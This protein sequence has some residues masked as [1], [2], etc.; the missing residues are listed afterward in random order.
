MIPQESLERVN[1]ALEFCN[2]VSVVEIGSNEQYANATKLYR[3]LNGYIKA[4]EE[5]RKRVKEPYFK[6]G[7][8]IDAWFNAPAADLLN[9]KSK[10]DPA[11]RAYDRKIEEARLEEQRR[12]NAIAEA[13]RKKKEQAAALERQKAE[14]KRR[15]AEEIAQKDAARAAELRRQAEAADVRAQEKENRAAMVTAPIAQ[16]ATPKAEG[17]S[18][19]QNWKMQI[20]NPFEFVKWCVENNFTMLLMPNPAACKAQAGIIR[21]ETV[22][23]WGKI[24]NDESLTGRSL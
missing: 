13:E 8:E 22:Y 1:K 6:K 7:K 2:S 17:I 20:D 23:S 21:K 24:F 5:E 9:L 19:R 3:E 12:L 11:I 4:V 18:K 16:T 14:E 10:L 15:E